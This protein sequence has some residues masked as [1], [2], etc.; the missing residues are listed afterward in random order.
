MIQSV[1][2]HTKRKIVTDDQ[3]PIKRRSPKQ[4]K[5]V[6]IHTTA[7]IPQVEYYFENG[8]ISLAKWAL[9]LEL[10]GLNK[11]FHQQGLRK[12]QPYYWTYHA[13]AKGRWVGRSLIEIFTTEFRDQ[14]KVYYVRFK[15]I[16][17]LVCTSIPTFPVY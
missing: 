11:F 13:F 16:T 5:T 12:V 3:S 9:Y 14:T 1:Q 15:A 6:D 2:I 17:F 4:R 7:D 8:E 10:A